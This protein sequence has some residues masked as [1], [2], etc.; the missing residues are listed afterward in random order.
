[1]A[2]IESTF[3]L[4]LGD[5][6][7]TTSARWSDQQNFIR[8]E[9]TNVIYG[10]GNRGKRP[11]ILVLDKVSPPVVI[12]CSFDGND[13][14]RDAEARLGL[15]TRTGQLKIK[16]A[17]SVYI[18]NR[19]RNLQ[20]AGITAALRGGQ[21]INYALHQL[22]SDVRTDTSVLK[23]RRWPT[24][25]FLPRTAQDLA[26]FLPAAALP[27]EEVE[28]VA[29]KVAMLVKAAAMGLEGAGA[30]RKNSGGGEFIT[31]SAL[32]SE[33]AAHHHGSVVERALDAAAVARSRR[34]GYTTS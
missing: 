4:S 21:S 27:K 29:D 6:L 19:F 11:D 9:E 5:A 13:A 10:S 16:S 15:F 8:V 25:G 3:N 17:V 14:D 32:L 2:T 23:N 30:S 28:R 31:T 24:R 34:C 7:R 22:V 26:A 33:R 1:M 20:M 18:P 12:E